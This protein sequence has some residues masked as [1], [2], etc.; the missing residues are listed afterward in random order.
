MSVF[1][2]FQDVGFILG[3][4]RLIPQSDPTIPRLKLCGAVLVVEMAALMLDETDLKPD[5]INL[6]CYSKVIL[7]YIYN[8]TK[9]YLY[10]HNRVQHI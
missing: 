6:Y 7:R 10:V 1:R 4:A 8:E 9:C 2:Y 3:K 5:T